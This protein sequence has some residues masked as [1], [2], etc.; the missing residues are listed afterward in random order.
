M[1]KTKL[2]FIFIL[3]YNLVIGQSGNTTNSQMLTRQINQITNSESLLQFLINHAA[4]YEDFDSL[5]SIIE[6]KPCPK[7]YTYNLVNGD[8]NIVMSVNKGFLYLV[9]RNF[10]QPSFDI[11][12]R[13]I[14]SLDDFFKKIKD[15]RND[16]YTEWHYSYM[17]ISNKIRDNIR[18]KLDSFE[19]TSGLMYEKT[20]SK[21]TIKN[22]I[23]AWA[24]ILYSFKERSIFEIDTDKKSQRKRGFVFYTVNQT[25]EWE[26]RYW[27]QIK[28]QDDEFLKNDLGG[29]IIAQNIS[30]YISAQVFGDIVFFE[31]NG[32]LVWIDVGR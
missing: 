14:K 28:Q 4:T 13:E 15:G 10:L 25:C 20:P 1:K 21:L 3:L 5:F 6:Q 11:D 2:F 27:N 17:K 22:N 12:Q 16:P 31:V 29:S 32:K 8:S 18:F 19:I 9:S 26:N 7:N 24:R 30:R 23:K